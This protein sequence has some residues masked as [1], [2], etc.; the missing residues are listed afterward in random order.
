[1]RQELIRIFADPKVVVRYV[2]NAGNVSDRAPDAKGFATVMP[3]PEVLKPLA[4][5]ADEMWPGAPVIPDMETGASDSIYT[6]AVGLPSYGINGVAIDQN[7]VRAHGKDE[8]VR[9]SS[10]YDGVEF[11]YRFLKALTSPR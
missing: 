5:V 11:Y 9:V 6:V 4:R 3:P 7:D 1:V 10:F 2:D 8:R